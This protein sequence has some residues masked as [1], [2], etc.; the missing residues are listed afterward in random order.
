MNAGEPGRGQVTELRD[1]IVA[2]ARRLRQSARADHESWTA[3]MA[4]GAI[5]RG[6]GNATPTQIAT[7]LEL[8]SSN[9]AQLLR[10][11]DQR[12]L[13]RRTPDASDKRK[14][15]LSL[16]EAGNIVVRESRAQRDSWLAGAIAACLSPVEQAQL[17]AAGDLLRRIATTHQSDTAEEQ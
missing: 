5:Q 1:Q 13:I 16:T 3:L 6:G 7:E 14:I 11:L 4:L 2:L 8:R 9:M 17:F 10:E 12:G 15:R